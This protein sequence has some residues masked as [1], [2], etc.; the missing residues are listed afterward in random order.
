LAL[1]GLT[2]AG[3]E[4][5]LGSAGPSTFA[6]PVDSPADGLPVGAAPGE[7]SRPGFSRRPF[8]GV[9]LVAV[10]GKGAYG[11]GEPVKRADTPIA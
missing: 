7:H 11:K 2:A 1:R 9:G 3:R 10:M 8:V 4:G 5:D 6:R